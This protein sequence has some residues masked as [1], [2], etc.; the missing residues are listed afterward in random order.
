MIAIIDYQM[1]NVQSVANALE[2]MGVA[3]T[4]TNDP[5]KIRAAEKLILPGVGAFGEGMNRLRSLG[6]I[7]ILKTEVVEKKKPILGIC[8]G[9]QLLADTGNEF[10][11][12]EGLGWIKGEVKRLQPGDLQLPHVGWNN[13]EAQTSLFTGVENADFYFVHSFHFETANPADVIATCDYGQ[14]FAAAVKHENIMGVQFHPEKSQKS[15]RHLLENFV[16][17]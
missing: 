14:R 11:R 3:H 1:G 9:M 7:D 5:E 10:G 6:L 12:H 17:S 15:G 2:N 4:I 16:K 8:L 13:V